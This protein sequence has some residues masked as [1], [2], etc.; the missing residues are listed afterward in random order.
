MELIHADELLIEQRPIDSLDK[1]DIVV[2][3]SDKS[4]DNDF[5]LI[6]P[7]DEWLIVPIEIG[8]TCT[9]QEQSSVAGSLA[10]N[11]SINKLK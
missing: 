3:L 2:S 11:T 4:T 9:S 6:V 1:W 10:L 7:E 8:H 5:Q